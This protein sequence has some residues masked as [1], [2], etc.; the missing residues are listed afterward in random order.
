[1]MLEGIAG[2]E[3]WQSGFLFCWP[4][5]SSSQTFAFLQSLCVTNRDTCLQTLFC[6]SNFEAIMKQK[7]MQAKVVCDLCS[8]YLRGAELSS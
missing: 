2:K 5:T 7:N 3:T 1:M 8:C 6:H 4:A